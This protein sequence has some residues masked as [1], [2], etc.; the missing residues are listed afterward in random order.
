MK[1]KR[2][3]AIHDLCSF[4][5]CSLTAAVPVL[6]AM[7]HQ[8]CPFPTA[9]YSNNLTYGKFVNRDLTDLMASYREQWK[10][11]GLSFDAVYSG[12]LAGPDQVAQVIAAIDQFAG[13]DRIAVVDPAM[14]DDGKLY[15]VFDDSMVE[16]MKKLVAHATLIT[17]NYTEACLLTDTPWKEEAPTED[18]LEALCDKL[19]ALGPK[20]VVITSVPCDEEHL[21]IVSSEPNQLFPEAYE[22]K[23]LP[24]ATCGTGDVFTSTLL[25]YVLNGRD[26][27]RCVQEAADYVSYVIDTTIKAGTDPK[28]GVVLEG[29]LWKLLFPQSKNCTTCMA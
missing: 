4:G 22:V 24:F 29:C 19:L 14:G 20:Q 12:F 9:L 1:I 23:R 28:E 27:N 17:P 11:L 21:K 6:S 7:G 8:V 10:A 18:E 2:V 3:L 5:R 13:E 25:G 26:L 16:A 15:P